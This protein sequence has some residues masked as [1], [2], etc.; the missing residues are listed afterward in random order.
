M[1]WRFLNTGLRRGAFNMEYDEHLAK[2]LL[3]GRGVPTLRAYG[4]KPYTISIGFHQEEKDIDRAAC[5]REG[6][7][8]VRRPTGGRA[9]LHGHELTYS[10]VMPSEGR[11]I[12][13]SHEWISR[14]LV[15]ALAALGVQAG[16]VNGGD[17]LS[18]LP[19]AEGS[20]SCF[21][22]TTRAE[23]QYQSRKIVGSAQR[24]YALPHGESATVLLQHGSILLGTDHRR[25]Y[26]FL[27]PSSRHD[28]NAVRE[29]LDRKTVEVETI[30][31]RSVSFDEAAGALRKGFE[32]ALRIEFEE[33]E[34]VF[35]YDVPIMSQPELQ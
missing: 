5:R 13:E 15:S 29:I 3:E 34:S 19:W 8:V 33:D 35:R 23:V 30:L 4:W 6:I 24:Q 32:D 28:R 14:G 18:K 2:R 16:M 11:S 21:A 1:T 20:V 26:E 7:D 9:I 17:A 27:S 31:G 25:L 12:A 10:V 22:S